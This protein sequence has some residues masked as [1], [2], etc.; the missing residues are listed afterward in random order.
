MFDKKVIFDNLLN[1]NDSVKCKYFILHIFNYDEH[2]N[3]KYLHY[4][5]ENWTEINN[6]LKSLINEIPEDY[7]SLVYLIYNSIDSNIVNDKNFLWVKKDKAACSFLWCYLICNQVN[8]LRNEL[9]VTQHDKEISKIDSYINGLN[10]NDWID[11]LKINENGSNHEERFLSIKLY[12]NIAFLSIDKQQLI[13]DAKRYWKMSCDEV[14]NLKWLSSDNNTLEWAWDYLN[15]Y[16]REQRN[17]H[18]S[19]PNFD[20]LSIN[21]FNPTNE[22]EYSLAIYAALRVWQPRF[23]GEKRLLLQDMSKACRQRKFRAE[24]ENKKSLNCYL[25]IS[26]K[27]HLD[28]LA[29]AYDKTI[30]DMVTYLIESEYRNSK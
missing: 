10:Y 5:L 13:S 26:V 15:K 16:G 24:R 23:R 18:Q 6:V 19:P 2:L 25:D 17:L 3:E 29:K 14:K 28:E 20:S 22:E 4:K 12:L 7:D 30:V 1:S 8:I 21:I 27:N 9:P 11:I